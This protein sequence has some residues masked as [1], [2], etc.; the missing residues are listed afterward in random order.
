MWNI[1]KY[2]EHI[3][4]LN[5]LGYCKTSGLL[6]KC[7][8]GVGFPRKFRPIL[9]GSHPLLMFTDRTV[10][11]LIELYKEFIRDSLQSPRRR[12]TW[13]I[14][15]LYTAQLETS[16]MENFLTAPDTCFCSGRTS[17]FSSFILCDQEIWG[18]VVTT[19]GGCA[20]C[21]GDWPYSHNCERDWSTGR[22]Y[23]IQRENWTQIIL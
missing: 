4:K 14:H 20:K 22:T 18:R 6:I 9:E 21:L 11:C 17:L 3:S 5:T 1:V 7:I 2:S 16:S 12:S 15:P 8:C 10:Q 23:Y 13:T 19:T